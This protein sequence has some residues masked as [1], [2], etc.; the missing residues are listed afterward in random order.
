MDNR[1]RTIDLRRLLFGREDRVRTDISTSSGFRSLAAQLDLGCRASANA[2]PDLVA[3]LVG[4]A[5]RTLGGAAAESGSSHD[6]FMLVHK[7]LL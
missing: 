3:R 4:S 7:Q 2:A 6:D 5:S 1:D